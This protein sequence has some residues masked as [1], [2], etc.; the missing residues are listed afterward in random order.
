MASRKSKRLL[1]L[2]TNGHIGGVARPMINLT[3]QLRGRGRDV[4]LLFPATPG[5]RAAQEWSG[6]QGVEAE[7]VQAELEECAD[8][9]GQ[10]MQMIRSLVRERNADIL[11]IHTGRHCL[12]LKDVLAARQAGVTCFGSI[13]SPVPWSRIGSQGQKRSTVLTSYLCRK[14]TVLSPWAHDELVGIGVPARKVQVIAPGSEVMA[15]PPSQ[16]EARQRLG[17]PAD[18]FVVTVF[19][20]LAKD[21]NVDKI[22]AAMARRTARTGDWLLIGGD[23]PERAA[24]ERQAQESLGERVRFVGHVADPRDIYASADAFALTSDAESF[25]IVYVEAALF[26]LPTIGAQNTAVP[27]TIL[28]GKTGLLVPTGDIVALAEAIDR[29]KADP[30]LRRTLGE[31]GRSR[32]LAEFTSAMVADQYERLFWPASAPLR[33]SNL[34]QGD[35][36]ITV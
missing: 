26:G 24:L 17:L 15:A 34:S 19:S 35:S 1:L 31:T 27:Q 13:Y 2:V 11:S 22:I 3:R 29:L 12:S 14:L 30:S 10:T 33:T 4:Q 18:A 36:R 9:N 21:K 6:Q 32:A 25:G 16:Q 20:R 23:G 8:R 5:G 7:C 28:D